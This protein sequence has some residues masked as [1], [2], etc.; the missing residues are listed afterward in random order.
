MYYLRNSLSLLLLLCLIALFM[1]AV[2]PVSQS[3]NKDTELKME[4]DSPPDTF[5]Y[6][7]RAIPEDF[8][9]GGRPALPTRIQPGLPTAIFP[10]AIVSDVVVDNTN[11]NL[12][13]TD[14]AN[15]GEP[16]IA[17]D[18]NNTNEI[19]ISAFS[20][21]WGANTP[22]WHS[23][24][25]GVTWT[26]QNT[27]PAPP[28]IPGATG[29]PCDQAF[30]FDRSNAVS[31]T[32][33]TSVDIFSGTTTDPTMSNVWN[34]LVQ[35]GIAQRTNNVTTAN[36]DQPWL[37][38]NRDPTTASQDNVYVAY[39]ELGSNSMRVAVSLGTNPPNFVRDNLSGNTGGGFVNPGHRLAVD[40]NNGAVYSL[41]QVRTGG[42]DDGSHN[43][44][45]RLNR[46]TDGGQTWTLNGNIA[47]IQIATGD[48]NQACVAGCAAPCANNTFK[49][50]TVNALLGGVLHAAVDPTNSD[51]YYVY[52]TRDAATNN[53]RL[54]IRRLTSNGMGGLNVGGEVF[55][56]GQV[57]AALPSV[58]VASDGTVGVLYT[59]FD[60]LS[61]MSNIP[62]FSVH[63][64]MSIDQGATFPTDLVLENFLSSATD[65]GACRQ[66]VLGDYQQ[67]KAVGTTFFGTFT[68]NGVPFGR[69]TAN[70]DPIFFRVQTNCTISCP[71]NISVSNDPGQCGA[72]VN[73][74]PNDISCGT[75]TCLPASGTVFPVGTTPVNCTTQAGPAC[76]FTITVNDTE[77]PVVTCPSNIT[78]SN[79]P[80]LCS[81]VVDP[82]TATATDNCSG[83]T[84]Q[85]VRS[86][87]LPL[88]APYPVGTTT[89]A[90]TATD[91][92]NNTDTC[93]QTITVNDTEPPVITAAVATAC[94][95]PPNH[96]LY[97]VGLTLAVADNCTPA[98]NIVVDVKITSDE[99]PEVMTKGDGNFSPDAVVTGTHVNRV[100]QLRRERM[101]GSDGR[102]YLIR[103]TATD[104]F[105]NSSLKVLRVGVPKNMGPAISC[106]FDSRPVSGGDAPDGGFFATSPP[107][108]I[109]GPK[110]QPV[111]ALSFKYVWR[112]L[113]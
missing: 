43:I 30:D 42:G 75:V 61:P 82:G 21:S 71:A 14:T 39:D 107:A 97:N 76:N 40:R 104:Q 47:G 29:C 8:A 13:N 77:D 4:K 101:G 102:V 109:I 53:N 25:G 92:S 22:I 55:I 78:V 70:H 31:G 67:V 33:L 73:Y 86:D 54:A 81:A 79:D 93:N 17:I 113:Q 41:W 26:E 90:W 37:L 74:D 63:F 49:F 111:G 28:G 52:G 24:D 18:P 10:T 72:V 6:T 89:I 112:F 34:W 32:F 59:Q 48:S 66:R 1:T 69:P 56:T 50:G 62:M 11:P 3:Q 96:D 94:L 35:M 87:G 105:N 64:A 88:N 83:V 7:R 60:G 20:G 5:P 57:Q 108:P 12:I 51:V 15:D 36:I 9:P 58:A 23:L 100:V 95:W 80:G 98:A 65:N 19:V 85:G 84:V 68:G 91:A 2:P 45:Y 44:S 16:S 110:L 27:V 46:S 99:K 103:I 38:V 106:G